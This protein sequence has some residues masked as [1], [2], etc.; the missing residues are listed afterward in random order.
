MTHNGALTYGTYSTIARLPGGV[1][2]AML[3][4]HLA[5]DIAAMMTELQTQS[6]SAL[7]AVQTW[8]ERD[9]YLSADP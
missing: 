7:N 1:T 9:L 4:N 6:I 2:L 8:P 5:F 3:F